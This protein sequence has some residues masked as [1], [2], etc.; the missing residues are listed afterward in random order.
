[1]ARPSP[2]VGPES[3]LVGRRRRWSDDQ[4]IESQCPKGLDSRPRW[5]RCFV[6]VQSGPPNISAEQ[7]RAA[8]FGSS[9]RFVLVQKIEYNL[10]P[11][12]KAWRKTMSDVISLLH[13]EL[14]TNT[15]AQDLGR[16][17][18]EG[19][20]AERQVRRPALARVSAVV[21]FLVYFYHIQNPAPCEEPVVVEPRL[22]HLTGEPVE[23][24]Q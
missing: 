7:F 22:Q 19:P 23:L 10:W 4:A 13:I 9:G 21:A 3:A 8:Q 24:E 6:R 11:K 20:D 2:V 15:Y 17:L 12:G 16:A 14:P 5:L 18:Q 1:M